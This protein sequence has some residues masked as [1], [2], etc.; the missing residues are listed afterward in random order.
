[1][2][3]WYI[4]SRTFTKYPHGTWSLLNILMIFGVKEKSIILTH[5]LYC[6][7][8]LQIY[9]C[10]LWLVLWSRVTYIL[11]C[12]LF[13]WCKAEFSA[14][15]LQSSVSHDPPEII[16]ICWFAAI[17]VETMIFFR[18]LWWKESSKEQH[19]FEIE[20]IIN[21][22]TV[23]FDQFNV[24]LVSTSTNLTDPKLLNVVWAAQLRIR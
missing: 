8:L 21:A 15:L 7:L 9:P 10:Y 4:Y 16:L 19:L 14:S 24:S 1:M 3:F 2:K 23:S 22:F 13:L 17:F 18:I 20:I 11:K 12:N 6:W 5:T